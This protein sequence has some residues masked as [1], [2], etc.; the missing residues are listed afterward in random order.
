MDVSFSV[1]G[2]AAAE[3]AREQARL[4]TRQ[5]ALAVMQARH[6]IDRAQFDQSYSTKAGQ[7]NALLERDVSAVVDP[8]VCIQFTQ[9]NITICI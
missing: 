2:A 9:G 1:G 7:L 6:D 3:Q 4:Q 8:T 5:K